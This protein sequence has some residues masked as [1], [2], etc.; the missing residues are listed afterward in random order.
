MRELLLF[1]CGLMVGVV[2]T[3]ITLGA[4]GELAW[5]VALSSSATGLLLGLAVIGAVWLGAYCLGKTRLP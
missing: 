1:W 4:A 3:R 2:G 5:D